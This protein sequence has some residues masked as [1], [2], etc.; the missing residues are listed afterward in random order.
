MLYME[1]TVQ[2]QKR[3]LKDVKDVMRQPLGE[4]GVYYIHDEDNMMKGYVMI[5]A[6]DDS[7]FR[8][9]FFFF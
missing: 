2:A 8:H 6:N 5:R 7:P 9:G 3:I 4:Q 1:P